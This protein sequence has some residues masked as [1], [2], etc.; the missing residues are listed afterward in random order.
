MLDLNYIRENPDK[1]KEKTLAKNI[2][3]DISKIIELDEKYRVKL[4]EVQNLREE[5]NKRKAHEF[6]K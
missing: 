4:Q 3:V 1:V 2:D 6:G 5:R